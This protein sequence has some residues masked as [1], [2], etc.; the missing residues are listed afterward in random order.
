[1]DEEEIDIERTELM[2]FYLA[3]L[4][5]VTGYIFRNAHCEYFHPA[6]K[7]FTPFITPGINSSRRSKA[8]RDVLPENNRAPGIVPQ[9]LTNRTDEFIYTEK[10]L[11]D[12]GYEEINLNLGCPSGTVVAKGRG[13][14]FLA[15]KDELNRFL[16]EIYSKTELKISIKTRLGKNSAEEFDGLLDI[17][18]QYPLEELIIHPRT[19]EDFYKGVPNLDMFRLGLEK[20]KCPV[21]YNGNIFTKKDYEIFCQKFP[22][23]ECIMI[24]RGLVANPALLHSLSGDKETLNKKVFR[25]FHDRIY[26]DYQELLSGDTNLLYKMKELWNY[27]IWMFSEAEKYNKKIKKSK[28]LKDYNRLIDE[29]FDTQEISDI[30]GFKP[31]CAE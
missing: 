22:G 26:S 28:K 4:E 29:L 14:G 9:I 24:G 27:M 23:V 16:D 17:Y 25:E 20:S 7:Y 8:L 18:N 21:C 15:F 11:K 1:M 13:S 19:R 12:M 6:D 10:Q 31:N 30:Q 2:K 5:G 3:P